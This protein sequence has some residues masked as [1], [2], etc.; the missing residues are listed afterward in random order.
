MKWISIDEKI[1]EVG[2]DVYYYF[3]CVGVHLG[4]FYGGEKPHLYRFANSKG[5]LTGDVTHWQP[6]TGQN[7]PEEPNE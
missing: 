1:P 4:K 5:W 2:Q 6:Y 7:R 3:E